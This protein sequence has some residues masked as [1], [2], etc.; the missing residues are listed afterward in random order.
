MQKSINFRH[1][2]ESW[3]YSTSSLPQPSSPCTLAIPPH[4]LTVNLAACGV[5]GVV[6]P[7]PNPICIQAV[8]DHNTHALGLSGCPSGHPD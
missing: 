5:V 6:A 2:K 3:W 4:T 8:D 1:H 7:S